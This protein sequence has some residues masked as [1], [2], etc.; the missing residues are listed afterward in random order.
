M[1]KLKK[2]TNDVRELCTPLNGTNVA[3]CLSV[4]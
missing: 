1:H 2:N 3:N 4:E